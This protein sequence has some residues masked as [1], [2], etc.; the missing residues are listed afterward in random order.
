MVAEELLGLKRAACYDLDAATYLATDLVQEQGMGRRVGLRHVD[1]DTIVSDWLRSL[2]DRDIRDAMNEAYRLARK[3]LARR[4]SAIR[5]VAQ[6][7]MEHQTINTKD[8]ER[9]LGPKV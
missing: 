9:L 8:L 6:C 7:L 5:A 4:K 3:S 1:E 2:I